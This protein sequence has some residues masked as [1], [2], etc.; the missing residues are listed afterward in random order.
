M[1]GG[2]IA[3]IYS[4]IVQDISLT[5]IV[6]ILTTFVIYRHRANIKRIMN[7]TEPKVKWLDKNK[8][9]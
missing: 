1:F 5:I 7:K 4:L 8:N 2:V 9:K 6:T 3:F